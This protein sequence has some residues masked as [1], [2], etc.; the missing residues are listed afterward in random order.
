MTAGQVAENHGDEWALAWYLR[1]ETYINSNLNPLTKFPS[2]S[3]SSWFKYIF[4]WN[5]YQTIMKTI[6]ISTRIVISYAMKRGILFWVFWEVSGNLENNM[7]RISQWRERL[8]GTDTS[9]RRK[10]YIQKS[11]LWESQSGIQVQKLTIWVKSFEI[12]KL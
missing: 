11:W 2:R 1:C 6:P 10:K 8:C 3:R 4:P 12:E 5:I 9:I 7:I